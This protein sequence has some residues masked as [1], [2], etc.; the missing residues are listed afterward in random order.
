MLEIRNATPFQFALVPS[1][2]KE[3]NDHVSIVVKGTF[4]ITAGQQD[5][6]LAAEQVPVTWGDEF[7][8]EPGVSSIASGADT[9]PLKVGTDLIL[10]GHA[11]APRGKTVKMADVTLQV[12]GLSRVVRV[13]GD[14]KWYRSLG[15]WRATEP[16][17]FQKMPLVYERAFGGWDKS[18]KAKP[19]QTHEKRNPVGTGF[20][21][22]GVQLEGVPLPN[23]ED[24]KAPI[25]S[26]GKRARAFFHIVSSSSRSSVMPDI[27]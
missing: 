8:G 16:E 3:G 13:V 27:S 20:S 18:D 14:R 4:G 5:L 1:L 25:K 12:G 19:G 24:P 26:Q 22:T 10:R 23:L 7:H 15:S 2:D 21:S 11:C 6:P 17:P 9:A